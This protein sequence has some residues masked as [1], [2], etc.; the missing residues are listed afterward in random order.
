MMGVREEWRGLINECLSTG[1][2]EAY[3]PRVTQLMAVR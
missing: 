3:Q 1:S 2:L